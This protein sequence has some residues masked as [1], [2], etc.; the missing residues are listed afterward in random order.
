MDDLRN[1]KVVDIVSQLES[2][3]INVVVRDYCADQKESQQL[4]GIDLDKPCPEKVDAIIIAVAHDKYRSM[5]ITMLKKQLKT[6][7]GILVDIKR[8]FKREDVEQEK[9]QYWGL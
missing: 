8:I 1:S 5:P 2:Y 6:K 4:Y 7:T 3:S 9:I